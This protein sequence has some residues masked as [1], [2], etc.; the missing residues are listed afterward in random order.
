VYK[1]LGITA[2]AVA[3]KGA[4]LMAHFAGAPAPS[5]CFNLPRFD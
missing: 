4:K 2:E 5:V 1:A 3:A